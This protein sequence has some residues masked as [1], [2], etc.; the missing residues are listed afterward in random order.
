MS[1]SFNFPPLH[2]FCVRVAKNFDLCQ[3]FLP[4][5]LST[6]PLSELPTNS[7]QTNTS[8]Q[9][10]PPLCAVNFKHAFHFNILHFWEIFPVS[11]TRAIWKGQSLSLFCATNFNTNTLAFEK[12]QS[13]LRFMRWISNAEVLRYSR[14]R[15]D[16]QILTTFLLHRGKCDSKRAS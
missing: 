9:I 14:W 7:V 6:F 3:T 15:S 1:N 11:Q 13:L 8:P 16:H 2:F 10:P 12:G 5:Q 4:F